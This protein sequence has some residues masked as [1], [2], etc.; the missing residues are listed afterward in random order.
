MPNISES[1]ESVLEGVKG[2]ANM[3]EGY[4]A[5]ASD[6]GE[7]SVPPPDPQSQLLH[8]PSSHRNATSKFAL[9]QQSQLVQTIDVPSGWIH[10]QAAYLDGDG[11]QR[12]VRPFGLR[13]LTEEEVE[14]EVESDLKQL[15]F[16]ASDDE[17]SIPSSASSTTSSLSTNAGLPSL[18]IIIPASSTVTL[19]IAFQ[20]S[21][22][23]PPFPLSPLS[24][25][26]TIDDG[27]Y[28]PRVKPVLSRTNSSELSPV[29]LSM[30]DSTESCQSVQSVAGN[31]RGAHV[32][33]R[34]EPI[35]RA[36]S[37]HGS[38]SIRAI[39]TTS[40]QSIALPFFATVC[41]SVFTA[42][43]IEP[44]SGLVTGSQQSSGDLIVDF[45]SENV[46]GKKYHRDILLVNRSEIELVWTTHVVNAPHK[47]SVWF[48]L[49]DLDSEN[50]FGVDHSSQPVPLPALSSRHLRLSLRSKAPVNDFEF[51]FLLSNSNQAGNIVTCKAIGSI[52]P[53]TADDSLKILS[54]PTLDFG[55]ITDKVWARQTISVRNVGDR[56]LDVRFGKSEG[57]EVVFRLAGVAGEDVDEDLPIERSVGI[58]SAKEKGLGLSRTSTRE[59]AYPADHPHIHSV[60]MEQ[61]KEEVGSE[62]AEKWKERDISQS[63]SSRPLSR[64]TSRTSSS[65]QGPYHLE[66]FESESEDVEAPFFGGAG[67][68]T[69]NSGQEDQLSLLGSHPRV[70][71]S[72]TIPAPAE[73]QVIPNQIEEITMR[74]GTEYRISVL[75]R[76]ASLCP[77]APSEIAGALRKS[78]FKIYLDATPSSLRSS[79]ATQTSTRRTISATVSSCTSLIRLVS[80]NVV[81]F[82][83]VT[84]GASKLTT[85]KIENLSELS[86]KVEIAA[87]SKVLSANKNV[88]V[89]PPKEVV[90][91]KLEFFPRRINEKYE[92]QIFIRNL[93]NRANDQLVE[94]KSRNVDVYNLT[95]HSHLYRILTPSG[96]NFL[97]FGSVVIN[98]PT[99]R[100]INI[101]NLSRAPLVLDLSASQPEDIE[102]FVKAEDSSAAK[103]L[104]SGKYAEEAQSSSHGGERPG[105]NGELKERFMEE[106]NEKSSNAGSIKSKK[107]REKSGGRV[108]EEN[109]EEI[110]GR[111][112]NIAASVATA[113]KKGSRGKPVQLYGNS[114]VFKDRS[115]LEPHEYLDL[116][117]GPPVAA[118]RSSPHSKRTQLLESIELEDKSKLS[119]QH[120]KVPK[121]DFAA[122]AKATGAVGKEGKKRRQAQAHSHH[123][124]HHH[125]HPSQARTAPGTGQH[126]P[127]TPDKTKPHLGSFALINKLLPQV[128]AGGLKSPAL[129]GKRIEPPLDN[130]PAAPIDPSKMTPD[131]L[132]LAI[133]Q[134]DAKKSSMTH[135][136]LEEEEAFVR[137]TI[138]LRKELQNLIANNR[139][140]PARTL[141]VAPGASRSLIVIMTPNSSIRPH[142][143]TR[144]K[145]ADSRIFIKL[146]EFDKSLLNSARS[147]PGN[148]PGSGS[149]KQLG[150]DQDMEMREGV[151]LPIRDL[152]IRSSCVRSVLEVQQSS[153][154]FGACDKGEVK[155]KTIVIHNKSDC[156]GLFRLRTS[157][158]IASGDLKLGLGRYG[159][160]SAFGRKQFDNFSFTPSL[161]GNYQENIT[162]ENVLDSWNDQQLAV[163]ATVR[164]VPAFIVDP[165]SLDFGVVEKSIRKPETKG[166]VITNVSKHERTFVISVRDLAPNSFAEIHLTQ[167]EK[168]AGTALSRVEEEELEA[169]LQKLKIARRKGK[170][171]KIAKYETRLLE[172]GVP[173]PQLNAGAEGEVGKDGQEEESSA[174]VAG[175]VIAEIASSVLTTLK[176]TKA[177]LPKEC[178]TKLNLTLAP[179][180]KSSILVDL[181]PRNPSPSAEDGQKDESL[182]D[183]GTS[184][185]IHD[186]KN[187][188]ET[189]S[190]SVIASRMAKPVRSRTMDTSN[191]S[192]Q[193]DMHGH[194]TPS[195]T[196][197]DPTDL[198][199]IRHCLQLTLNCEVSPTAFCVGSTLFLPSSSSYYP[200]LKSHFDAFPQSV[201]GE[202]KGLILADGW[203][204]QIPGNTHAEAN[205]LTN[206][207][208][209][210]ADILSDDDGDGEGQREDESLIEGRGYKRRE[211]SGGGEDNDEDEGP[212]REECGSIMSSKEVRQLA[213]IEMVLKDAI[214]FAT[215]E[216]CS[217][218]TSGGPSCALELVRAGVKAVYLGV[219]EPPDFVECE[220]V[221]ILQDGGVQ[222]VRV[223]G[224]E[225]DCL[226]AARRGRT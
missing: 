18:Q 101:E 53:T 168:D 90:E 226:K 1:I 19:F 186:R 6:N 49:R 189:V 121:L 5:P 13:N 45:G 54:G 135:T 132:L 162:I 22:S 65:H 161:V 51:S 131:Q 113:L 97:D 8:I 115:L 118:H 202:P 183:V 26:D 201:V 103:A 56:T 134:H 46:M 79:H 95:L 15:L 185:T 14:V 78:S 137:R 70:M 41:R 123:H 94:I 67:G 143:S 150:E 86:T 119:G 204:R 116:A 157:G 217:Y 61:G 38:V 40:H 124:T 139:L 28:T 105:G 196:S 2:L 125:A 216:P 47:D 9:P 91:E 12:Q 111:K 193:E 87:M 57:V 50:V 85:I 155:S 222:V 11:G 29:G 92:K 213:P 108:K 76:P 106:L 77:S 23:L 191:S 55:E 88:I 42:G 149:R 104:A 128:K 218:R 34:P 72:P 30:S 187:T 138:A 58:S 140:I 171:E 178:I 169:L 133:E 107:G 27:G 225:E 10:L 69:G 163:K 75:H 114:V 172:L 98:S 74:P 52:L 82:G 146:L 176:D 175:K 207:R 184:I 180:Q 48:E 190:V 112:G 142:I 7:A 158:S 152:I 206:F 120:P 93:L 100:I 181:I 145:R 156:I 211:S 96:S 32:A 223:V 166:F 147:G 164:K 80:G 44:V 89:I 109:G 126:T 221:R 167:D 159:V 35:H 220:G 62:N 197:S 3:A 20:P 165:L 31:M 215:M 71:A 203:S 102:L 153:I 210:Y 151:E 127:K 205:A 33:K 170:T 194:A 173:K 199:L 129:T 130:P 37:V 198:A 99:I 68:G 59:M 81:D 136:T 16:W 17:K 117:S 179:K 63:G 219:E 174:S 192:G 182:A 160:I 144:A 195:A 43:P 83:Q 60:S 110:G 224:L 84:V 208:I 25:I 200:P 36:F 177:D 24:P 122:G 212:A 66:G 73:Q 39:T 21:V 214:C 141:R 154:N 64:I 4:L 148:T 209:K 188:D